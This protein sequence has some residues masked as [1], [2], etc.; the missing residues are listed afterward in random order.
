MKSRDKDF[1]YMATSDL[2]AG[3]CVCRRLA[4]AFSLLS[5]SRFSCRNRAS[6]RDA[7]SRTN[8]LRRAS[9]LAELQGG[10]LD[11]DN[12]AQKKLVAQVLELLDD[13]SND[14]QEIAAK[15]CV[16]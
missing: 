10:K 12:S 11:I 1:R 2:I 16:A 15:W 4:F 9:T 13:T 6:A 8:A 7:L 3:S 5:R 14:V